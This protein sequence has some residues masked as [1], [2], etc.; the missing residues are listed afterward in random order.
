M[1]K[2][3]KDYVKDV[4]L[5]ARLSDSP[6]CLVSGEGLSL[7]MEKVLKQI[8]NAT[9]VKA[10]RILEIN[11]N[12]PL[13]IAI[14]KKFEQDPNSIDHYASILYH[15]ALLIEGLSIEDPKK[16]SEDLI[17]LMLEASK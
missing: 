8:P 4:K 6:V 3:L 1:K 5:S 12:H 15:Q 16:F 2:A 11:P 7:E 13:L 17:A 14:N 9:D 10:E